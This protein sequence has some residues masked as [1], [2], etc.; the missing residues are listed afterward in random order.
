MKMTMKNPNPKDIMVKKL[1]NYDQSTLY[2]ELS[3]TRLWYENWKSRADFFKIWQP[4][5]KKSLN[6]NYELLLIQWFSFKTSSYCHPCLVTRPQYFASINC[7]G[8]YGQW[9]KVFRDVWAS[10]TGHVEVTWAFNMLTRHSILQ[11]I[12]AYLTLNS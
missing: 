6:A 9:W 8:S 11:V 3:N 7:F 4:L 5:L 12:L 1:K 2:N 10:K